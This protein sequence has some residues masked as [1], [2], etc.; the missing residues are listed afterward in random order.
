MNAEEPVKAG[1]NDRFLLACRREAADRVPVWLMRQAGRS[2]AEY[3]KL[4]K[5]HSF[6]ELSTTPELAAKVTM[7]PVEKLGVDAA[8][9]FSDLLTPAACAGFKVE[10]R[11]GGP[12]VGNPVR[13]EKEIEKIAKA[14]FGKSA[15]FVAESI[16]IL[17]KELNVPLIGFAG[18][19]FTMATYLVEGGPSKHFEKTKTLINENPAFA[20]NLFDAL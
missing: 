4:R 5:K 8:I 19:P 3:R 11:K 16:K 2:M 17:R 1:F 13:G 6:Q 15:G 18:A 20:W 9:L 12:V 10:Y 7:L 14:D